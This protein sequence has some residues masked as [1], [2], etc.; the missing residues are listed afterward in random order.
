M[1][2]I[3]F[4]DIP[5]KQVDIPMETET[6]E[7]KNSAIKKLQS[8]Q[9]E[10]QVKAEAGIVEIPKSN[11]QIPK[12]LPQYLFKCGANAI[13]CQKFNLDEDEAKLM[14]KHLSILTGNINSKWFSFI[15]VIVVIISKTTNCIEAIQRKFGKKQI[16]KNE[17]ITD[18]NTVFT[19]IKNSEVKG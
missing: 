5:K 2:E 9:V 4:E 17:T 19:E 3:E 6:E 12:E 10:T 11:E 16:P 7:M 13:A 14:A 8:K 15:I 18:T 1:S